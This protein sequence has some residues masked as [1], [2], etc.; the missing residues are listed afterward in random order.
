MG[1]VGA[2][3]AL[4]FLAVRQLI[5][6][7]LTP[8]RTYLPWAGI[9]LVGIAFAITRI[10]HL[11]TLDPERALFM[12]RLQYAMSYLLP[13][14][15]LAT[16]DFLQGHGL[17]RSTKLA[18]LVSVPAI[19]TGVVTPWMVSGPGHIHHDA[20][21]HPHIGGTPGWL[22]IVLAPLT[23]VLL[24]AVVKKL[25]TASQVSAR[26]R[27]WLRLGTVCFVLAGAHDSLVGAG[28]LPSVFVLEYAYIFFGWLAASYELRIHAGRRSNLMERYQQL[29]DA[30]QEGVFVCADGRVID[31]NR[32][33]RAM[34]GV[35]EGEVVDRDLRDVVEPTHRGE[36][37]ELLA[38][39]SG[40]ID[41]TLASAS[42]S[43]RMRAVTPPA[44]V[45]A[46]RVVLLRDTTG[47]RDMQ[48]RL[49]LS[50]RLAAIGTLAAGTA[51][52]I[53][54]PLAFVLTNA[55]LLHDE[56]G[57]DQ[58]P[59]ARHW[60]EFTQDIAAGAL[61]I[62]RVVSD[63]SSLARD[64]QDAPG[65]VDVGTTLDRCAAMAAPQLRHRARL[66]KSY[67]SEYAVL[68]DEGRLFQVFLNLIINAAQAIP[69][70]H[71][72]TNSITLRTRDEP[73]WVVI[74][75]ADTGCG[76][77]PATKAKIFTPF[78]TTK[79]VGRGTGLGLSISH[80]IVETMGGRIDVDSAVGIGTTFH[81]WLPAVQAAV[82]KRSKR[83]SS[84]T[85]VGKL[86]V[87]IIDDEVM[88]ANGF[89]RALDAHHVQVVH[90]GRDALARLQHDEFDLAL[91]DLMMPD[92]TGMELYDELVATQ[93]PAAARC[94]F[95]TGGALSDQ[96]LEFLR[97]VGKD[98]WL[99]KPIP[100]A[101]LQRIAKNVV[102][103]QPP[104]TGTVS[105]DARALD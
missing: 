72:D 84:I 23:I 13:G 83:A 59:A 104:L 91:C 43:G 6:W 46:S 34:L 68:A 79:E 1:T 16:L 50:D 56:L 92:V 97:T 18:L 80:N 10:V 94:V 98:R 41:V 60:R 30:T 66:V 105:A 26:D 29:A 76:M 22:A 51:H 64:R 89:A 49:A 47:E 62:K 37:E 78:F 87:L 86:R 69:E 102:Q 38:G 12:V 39:E 70:G 3:G 31:A 2:L 57:A 33:G 54:N 21:G 42:I 40:P 45:P 7:R 77:D 24:A 74:S 4:T 32:A 103:G 65:P 55:E 75:V 17:S 100:L 27:R 88:V 53:N 58:S 61:R 28:V 81:V 20:F 11:T 85:E 8:E 63:L 99:A 52:E 67:G 90:S 35:P 96:S 15:A 101:Q 44:G 5:V 19:V 93:N 48:A 95:M 25:R 71:F 9:T 14:F 73:G 82:S 36:V